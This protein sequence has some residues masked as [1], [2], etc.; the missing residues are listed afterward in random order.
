MWGSVDC[1]PMTTQDTTNTPH[2]GIFDSG[3][4]GLSVLRSVRTAFPHARLSYL[5]DN[6][7]LPY[8][9]KSPEWLIARC[10]TLTQH[11]LDEGASLILVACNTAT[12][13]T[14]SALRARWPDLPFV[15]IE[16]GIKP[17]VKATRN[18]RI[19][20]MATPA[21]LSSLRM[22]ELIALHAGD[23]HVQLLPCPGLATAIEEANDHQ[24]APLLDAACTA[25]EADRVDT[26]VL[27]CTHYPL[28][29]DEL[30][31]RLGGGVQLIDTAEAVARRILT[32]LPE[33]DP[34]LGPLESEP[35]TFI[36]TGA[37]ESVEKALRRWIPESAPF[38]QHA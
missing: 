19:S 35:I 4:G 30:A 7:N 27:G 5:A 13:H 28:I 33:R 38:R 29:A 21:T 1:Q 32:L 6:R 16:P 20:V 8:G 17:A 9:D 24:L 18:R 22:K 2:I 37:I 12:T 26:V 11:L 36:A 15:G 10:T 25:L 34:G 3:V 23:C 14:I 31:A